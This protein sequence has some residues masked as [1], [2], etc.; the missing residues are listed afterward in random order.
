MIYKFSIPDGVN[1]YAVVVD[2]DKNE[3][4]REQLINEKYYPWSRYK[5][6]GKIEELWVK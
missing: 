4:E 6:D 5:K 1:E 3:H 2:P